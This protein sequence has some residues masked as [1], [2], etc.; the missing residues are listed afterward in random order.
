MHPDWPGATE[1]WNLLSRIDIADSVE[2]TVDSPGGGGFTG[3]TFFVEGIHETSRPLNPDYDDIEITLDL[4]AAHLLRRQPLG[5]H[6]A[7]AA[8][9]DHPRPRPLPDG[10]DPIGGLLA[11]QPAAPRNHRR[12]HP[13]SIGYWRLGEPGSRRPTRLDAGAAGLTLTK[14][15]TTNPGV[16]GGLAPTTPPPRHFD[17]D[18]HQPSAAANTLGPRR[19]RPHHFPG[20]ADMTV[21]AWVNRQRVS[22]HPPAASS[23]AT[24]SKTPAP[25]RLAA[26]QPLYP[27]RT[28]RFTH[29]QSRR[30]KSNR[31]DPARTHRGRTG[32]AATPTTAPPVPLYFNGGLVASGADTSRASPPTSSTLAA[33]S[34][35]PPTFSTSSAASTGRRLELRPHRRTNRQRSPRPAPA[36]ALPPARDVLTN[37]GAGGTTWGQAHARGRLLDAGRPIQ[38]THARHRPD[39]H[40]PRRRRH[41]ARSRRRRRNGCSPSCTAPCPP[42]PNPAACTGSPTASAS[43]SPTP[44]NTPASTSATPAQRQPR[45]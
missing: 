42:A 37:D 29:G 44:S 5:R 26:P 22:L 24:A 27:A 35:S 34:T 33:A 31:R 11:A 17:Y 3:Q 21:A 12:R 14:K 28:I 9:A 1:T 7:A 40:R 6:D 15:D 4:S 16:T 8:E 10:A 2:V 20:T 25:T 19:H 38:P 36:A 43:P 32:I 45:S 39:R 30:R 18:R 41:R 13:A 23:S